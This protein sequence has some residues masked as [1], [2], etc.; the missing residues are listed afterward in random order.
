MGLLDH[1]AGDDGAVLQHVLEVH[2]VAVVH[3]L[4]VVVGIVEVDD[5]GLVRLDHIGGEQLAHGQV[6]GDLA[7]HVVALD[8]HHGGV[9]VRVLLLDLLVVRLDQR[10]DLVVG[11]VLVALLVL[12]IA[13]DDVLAGDGEA[14]ERHELVLDEVLDLLDGDGVACGLAGVLDI[15]GGEAHLALGEALVG[16]H[17]GV[18]GVDG[19]HDLLE[20]ELHLGAVALDDL[21][22][23]SRLLGPALLPCLTLHCCAV[24]KVVHASACRKG[25]PQP[26]HTLCART[27]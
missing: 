22:V 24:G 18:C 8:G 5:A 13:V 14:I 27:L 19:I 2:Q 15:Q 3:V 1:G 11:R 25:C 12:Q 4:G 26:V 10:E 7:G 17:L 20:V 16:G 21:H 23:F 6:L 9:L